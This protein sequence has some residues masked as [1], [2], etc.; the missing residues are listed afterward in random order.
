MPSNGYTHTGKRKNGPYAKFKRTYKRPTARNAATSIKRVQNMRTGGFLGVEH[1]FFD[2]FVDGRA[3]TGS[4]TQA[5]GEQDPTL[6]DCLN[7]IA[8]GSGQS[9][10]D[11]RKVLIKRCTVKG[12]FHAPGNADADDMASQATF[13]VALV[14]DTQTNGAQLS[15]ETVFQ[16]LITAGGGFVSTNP[17]RNME[18]LS[19]F[20]VLKQIRM[21]AP[22]STAFGDGTNTGTVA[23]YQLQWEIDVP[24][25]LPV[26]F[27]SA[28]GGGISDIN[29]N[30]LHIIAWTS[31]LTLTP[32]ISYGAR[33]RFLG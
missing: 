31:S 25:N 26:N 11:G 28:D 21:R 3:L 1:K 16:N 12:A 24:M 32:L 18:F 9:Q 33:V 5:N 2:S 23:G 4:A 19:R 8:Q 30:T 20:K 15:S 22:S 6:G 27:N 10:R 7:A 13:F 14:L 29:D 17:F